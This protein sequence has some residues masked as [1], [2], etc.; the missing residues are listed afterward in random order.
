MLQVGISVVNDNGE[1]FYEYRVERKQSDLDLSKLYLFGVPAEHLS[2]LRGIDSPV[3]KK[4]LVTFRT[5]LI[6]TPRRFFI[7]S[8]QEG[9]VGFTTC[10]QG[11][12]DM[13]SVVGDFVTTSVNC[14]AMGLD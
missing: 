1:F 5:T 10:S 9:T 8:M 11:E 13:S 12:N 4:D 2:L 6:N 7:E 3:V 14:G